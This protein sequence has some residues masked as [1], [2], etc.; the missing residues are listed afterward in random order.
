MLFIDIGSTYT[1]L[2]VIDIKKCVVVT[3]ANSPTTI[4][5]VSIGF[6]NALKKIKNEQVGPELLQERYASSSAAGGLRMVAIGLVPA[7]TM[8]AAKRAALGAGA[9]VVGTFSFM[10]TA[11][12]IREIENLNPD[13]ILLAGGT[14]GGE[15]NT[16][17]HNAKMIADSVLGVPVIMAGNRVAVEDAVEL[18]N[19]AGKY[20]EVAD[21]VMP[22]I[23]KLNVESVRDVIREIFIKRIVV[24]KG[25][26]KIN[27]YI[28]GIALPTPLAVLEAAKTFAEVVDN[29]VV[30][31]DIGGAT[32][33][34]YSVAD[35]L[36]RNSQITVK[37]L[38]ELYAKRTVEGDLG[39][40]C[41][42]HSI[43]EAIG[44]EEFVSI[45][46]GGNSN[47]LIDDSEIYQIL[48]VWANNTSTLPKNHFE[49][50]LDYVLASSA[51]KVATDRHAGY[52]EEMWTPD[53]KIPI[54]YGK[55]LSTVDTLIGTGGPVI[56]SD[57][58]R[59]ILD[60]AIADPKTP[61]VLKP[62]NPKYYVDKN[63]I[64]F[65]IGL[66]RQ[67]NEDIARDIAQYYL[68]KMEVT[69]YEA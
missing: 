68:R 18:F 42:I 61:F 46:K 17:I 8:E 64:L 69:D 28:D 35:G 23:G 62:K 20:F 1:K 12:Q 30:V 52:I 19:K 45:V 37:G 25:L 9:K 55:D 49:R 5:D 4:E 47:I 54:Q 32:T 44:E 34:V 41:N 29:G 39:V 14:D 38:P 26:S 27:Q 7:L 48:D 67:V 58:P 6:H 13:I 51:V 24:A 53:G 11:K 36:P 2:V 10:L 57:K 16:V 33:D 66:I 60:K 3:T 21:N 63:Y 59:M 56:N 31:V 40:R 50:K 22:T 43:T 15:K 65:S